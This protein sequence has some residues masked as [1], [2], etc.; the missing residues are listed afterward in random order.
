MQRPVSPVEPCVVQVVQQHHTQQQ[1]RHLQAIQKNQAHR[2]DQQGPQQVMH[3][4]ARVWWSPPVAAAFAAQSPTSAAG[5]DVE[6]GA[7]SNGVLAAWQLAV[8]CGF[9]DSLP[10]VSHVHIS[11]WCQRLLLA[12]PCAHLLFEAHSSMVL[13]AKWS[14]SILQLVV[15]AQ[16]CCLYSLLPCRLAQRAHLLYAVDRPRVQFGHASCMHLLYYRPEGCLHYYRTCKPQTHT[17][18]YICMCQCPKVR[19]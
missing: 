8:L 17:H 6:P 2:T 13:S 15:P 14:L 9:P 5:S 11:S 7:L 3:R 4:L 1:V 12:G 19:L 10:L 18:T 16:H